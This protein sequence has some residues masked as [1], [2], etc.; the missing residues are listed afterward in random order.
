MALRDMTGKDS[1]NAQGDSAGNDRLVIRA[2]EVT[3]VIPDLDGDGHTKHLTENQTVVDREWDDDWVATEVT[4]GPP[5]QERFRRGV[6]LSA[7]ALYGFH[8]DLT[9]DRPEELARGV[10]DLAVAAQ[11]LAG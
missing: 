3:D 4:T 11:S 8:L 9:T 10:D 1:P 2:N 6:L 5:W 7:A